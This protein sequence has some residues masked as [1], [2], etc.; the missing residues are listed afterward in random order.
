MPYIVKMAGGFGYKGISYWGGVEK[1]GTRADGTTVL[2]YIIAPRD[3]AKAFARVADA[4]DEIAKHYKK[5]A[6]A[7]F[8]WIADEE[9]HARRLKQNRV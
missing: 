1:L 7:S 5:N 3:Q 8:E 4:V 2:S 6:P 9:A